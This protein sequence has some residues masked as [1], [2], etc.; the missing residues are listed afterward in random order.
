MNGYVY[1]KSEPGL[2]TVGFYAPSGKWEPESD[3]NSTDKA[4]ERVRWLNG[5]R[6]KPGLPQ[7]HLDAMLKVCEAA[8][9]HRNDGH[10]TGQ[11]LF[12]ALFAFERSEHRQKEL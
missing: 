2:W 5:G 7:E 3:F 10:Y 8:R 11:R 12:D 9:Q 4:A 1:I 6:V